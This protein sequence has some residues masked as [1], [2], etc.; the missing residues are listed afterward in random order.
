MAIFF[1]ADFWLESLYVTSCLRLTR[2]RLRD[3][4]AFL[5]NVWRLC[6]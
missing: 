1:E 2:A 3:A 6:L 4:P 5:P